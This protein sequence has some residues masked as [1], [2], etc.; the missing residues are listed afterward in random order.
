MAEKRFWYDFE[1]CNGAKIV[2]FENDKEYPLETIGDFRKIEDLLNSQ[3]DENQRLKKEF[4]SFSHNW[5]L[6]YDEAKNKVEE[7]SKENKKLNCINKQLED[8]LENSGIG[9]ALDMGECE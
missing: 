8:R 4:D 6:M 2:D 3:H 7:L 5:A 9:V 1:D